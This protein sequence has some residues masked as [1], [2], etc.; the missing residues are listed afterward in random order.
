VE[1]EGVEV[2]REDV[3]GGEGRADVGL[4]KKTARFKSAAWSL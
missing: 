2:G 3:A 1:V 4:A